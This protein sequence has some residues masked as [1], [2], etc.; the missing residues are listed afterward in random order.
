M[1]VCG[2]TVKLE[3]KQN[4]SDGGK[5]GSHLDQLKLKDEA[6]FMECDATSSGQVQSKKKE[7][8]SKNFIGGPS[9]WYGISCQELI[10]SL[11]FFKFIDSIV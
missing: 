11:D 3:G 8:G 7:G 2:T 6:N 9:S 10:T 5:E 4:Q 1:D